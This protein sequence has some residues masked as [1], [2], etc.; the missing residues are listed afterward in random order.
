MRKTIIQRLMGD[1]WGRPDHRLLFLGLDASGR[2]VSLYQLKDGNYRDTIPTIGF[3]VETFRHGSKDFTA[4]DIGG[5]DKIRPL[6]RHYFI[7]TNYFIFFVDSND[8]DRLRDAREELYRLLQEEALQG[9]PFC[10]AANKQDLKNAMSAPDLAEFL[11]LED[12]ITRGQC[13][14]F[15]TI[16]RGKICA[17]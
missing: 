13:A 5:C 14:V 16:A 6:W 15:P 2:T 7:N 10:V 11:G 1:I 17:K 12:R 3:N 4:W 8:R 9:I